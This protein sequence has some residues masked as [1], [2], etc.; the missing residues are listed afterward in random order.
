MLNFKSADRADNKLALG[1]LSLFPLFNGKGK[2][3]KAVNLTTKIFFFQLQFKR[4]A[5]EDSKVGKD[6]Q[7]FS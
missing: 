7:V 5:M 1:T 2:S 3:L 6:G 4:K